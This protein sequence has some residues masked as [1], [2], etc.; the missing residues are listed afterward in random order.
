MKSFSSYHPFVLLMF[1]SAMIFI[2]IFSVHPFILAS[3]FI[4][5]I[6][7]YSILEKNSELLSEYLFY[8]VFFIFIIL[9]NMLFSHDGVTPI[10]FIN[11]KPITMESFYFG[12][13]TASTLCSVLFWSKAYFKI[14][15]VDKFLFLFSNIVPK[16][17]LILSMSMQF[18]SVIKRDF[19]RIKNAQITLGIFSDESYFTNLY[20]NLL[21]ARTVLT[22]SLETSIDKSDSMKARGYF[23]NSIKRS[24][25]YK[26]KIYNRDKII[27]SIFFIFS[28][29]FVVFYAMKPMIFNY[30]PEM[31]KIELNIYFAVQ[32]ISFFIIAVLPII[33]EIK[34]ELYWRYL[35]SKI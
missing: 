34:E 13:S 32:M 12:I 35:Q 2:T 1:Y 23:N 15:T 7:F 18:I 5:S 11:D 22:K 29:L 30:Y 20:S 28:F 19:V 10:L 6:I 14:F 33:I 9:L 16:L 26:Y 3:S 17:S 25:Y 31:S 4:C 21:V 8:F 24:T 27:M